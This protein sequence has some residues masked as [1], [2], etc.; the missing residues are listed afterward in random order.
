MQSH[1]EQ[2]FTCCRQIHQNVTYRFHEHIPHQHLSDTDFI[3]QEIFLFLFHT[4]KNLWEPEL[5]PFTL[6]NLAELGLDQTL[7]VK[8][9]GTLNWVISVWN[10]CCILPTQIWGEMYCMFSYTFKAFYV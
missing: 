4:L 9:E 7:Q 1:A 3:Q 2:S 6:E 5:P 8:M 10:F